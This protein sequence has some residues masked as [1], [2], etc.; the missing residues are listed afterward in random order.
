MLL[1]GHDVDCCLD[2]VDEVPNPGGGAWSKYS[3]YSKR[4]LI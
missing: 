2:K 3:T 4:T 1:T